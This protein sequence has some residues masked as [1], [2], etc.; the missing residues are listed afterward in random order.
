MKLE[1]KHYAAYLPFGVTISH[2]NT[3]AS[4]I[5]EAKHIAHRLQ[6]NSLEK[7]RLHLKPM[8]DLV[9][10]KETCDL[11]NLE[12][13]PNGLFL[14]GW[15]LLQNSLNAV[16]ISYEEMQNVLNILYAKHYDV[17]DLIPAGLAVSIHD[18]SAVIA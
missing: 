7:I 12:L 10:D 5:M 6:F 14:N 3:K 8:F 11:L 18:V 16:A 9:A 1:L 4:V 15:Y 2:E 13:E 17:F